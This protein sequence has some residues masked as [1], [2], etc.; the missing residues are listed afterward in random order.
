MPTS[1][2]PHYKLQPPVMG[3]FLSWWNV[4]HAET[5][6]GPVR[7]DRAALRRADSINAVTCLPAYQRV[8]HRMLAKHEGAPWTHREQDRIAALIGLAA[9]LHERDD[10]S[11]PLAMSQRAEGVDRNAVS[12]LRFARL[13]D[14]PDLDALFVGLRRVMPLI[15]HRADPAQMANDLFGWGDH[16]KKR[17]AYAYRWTDKAGS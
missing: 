12:D 8:F 5:A 11:L 4:L 9:H 6:P 13:L 1:S 17:W 15:G 3:E 2:S 10:T 16:V 14:S 7:A